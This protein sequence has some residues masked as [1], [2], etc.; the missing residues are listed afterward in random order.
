MAAFL[1]CPQ[2]LKIAHLHGDA[3]VPG[4]RC[5]KKCGSKGI[6]M[7]DGSVLFESKGSSANR[8]ASK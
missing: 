4:E 7:Q 1:R 5:F 6:Q 3:R 8:S 2:M